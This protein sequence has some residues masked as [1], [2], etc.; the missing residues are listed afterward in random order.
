MLTD[1]LIAKALG[2]GEHTTESTK[3]TLTVVARTIESEVCKQYEA[4][5]RQMLEALEQSQ[6]TLWEEDD[7]PAPQPSTAAQ[8]DALDAA[9]YRLVR[10]GQHW[11]VINGIGNGLR[12]EELDAAVDAARKQGVNHDNI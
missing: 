6:A 8:G 2:F 11:S 9:R 10:R 7:D 5:I 1:E 4:L 3:A 12:G